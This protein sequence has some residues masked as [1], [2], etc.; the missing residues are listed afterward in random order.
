MQNIL[1]VTYTSRAQTRCAREFLA[2]QAPA[3]SSRCV[4]V[5]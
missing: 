5:R 2:A 3:S 4:C 1:Y